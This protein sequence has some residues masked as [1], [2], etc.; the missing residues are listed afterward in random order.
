MPTPV[1][2]PVVVGA[3]N[4]VDGR[5]VSVPSHGDVDDK[6]RVDS[7][8]LADGKNGAL[9]PETKEAHALSDSDDNGSDD[10]IIVTGADAAT[11]LLPL[12]DDGEPA[13]TFRSLLLATILSAF[14]AVMTQI[15]AV[16]T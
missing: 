5:V 12:R 7:D 15:Y 6:I 2:D 14:Q 9:T 11:H 1:P 10:V 4:P 8:G 16:C 13:L 3:I